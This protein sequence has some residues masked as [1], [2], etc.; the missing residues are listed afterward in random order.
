MKLVI[1][2]NSDFAELMYY[3]FTTDSQYEV[4]GFC[5]DKKYIK[6]KTFLDKPL[7]ALEEVDKM[8]HPEQ[9]SMFV[10]VGY[11][12]MRLRKTLF[13]KTVSMGYKHVNY[14]SSRACFD[15]SNIIGVNNALLH[16]VVLEPFTKIGN[17]NII[18]TNS[19]ICHHSEIKDDC[20][21][22]A[23]STVGGFSI[24]H[25]NC[26][27]GFSSTIL[28]KLT[29]ASETLIAAGTIMNIDSTEYTMYAGVPAKPISSH[30][31]NGIQIK[32]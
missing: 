27:I 32:G 21:I 5:V 7:V 9:F 28:Q 11:K 16:N 10:A 18:N 23:R 13:E 12:S 24:V 17:N 25:N 4:V 26:F 19:I 3:Y 8:F 1:Y 22:A 30:Q 6:S 20:F 14:I 15:E 2:G 29:I 31:E